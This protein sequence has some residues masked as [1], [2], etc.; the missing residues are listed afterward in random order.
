MESILETA[1]LDQLSQDLGGDP[2]PVRDLIQSY[3][4]EAP[5][6]LERVRSAL[7]RNNAADL[8]AAAHSLKSSSAMLGA[9]QVSEIASELER[10]G[11]AGKITGA[12]E[13]FATMNQL[14]PRVEQALRHWTPR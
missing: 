1:T 12:S 9:R 7:E 2:E 10:M 4:H 11:R 13:K 14:F 8:A 5:L 6:A 3:L